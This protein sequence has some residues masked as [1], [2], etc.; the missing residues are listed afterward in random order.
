ME[1]IQDYE[2]RNQ[3]HAPFVAAMELELQKD[4]GLLVFD[5]EHLLNTMP[6]QIDLLIT[7]KD[8]AAMPRSF[9]GAIFKKYNLLEYN[10]TK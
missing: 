1:E 10:G 4:K 2:S 7:K 3:Y 9:L 6:N 8:L 5:S